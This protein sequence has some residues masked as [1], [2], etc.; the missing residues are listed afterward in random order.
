MSVETFRVLSNF[1]VHVRM[2]SL[3]YL[4]MKSSI[5][6]LLV[7]NKI[8]LKFAHKPI[9]IC[10]AKTINQ[11]IKANYVACAKLNLSQSYFF[12][13]NKKIII[14]IKYFWKELKIMP[15]T[16]L[17]SWTEEKC[18]NDCLK[19]NYNNCNYKIYL[20]NCKRNLRQKCSAYCYGRLKNA[21]R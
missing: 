1:S 18:N 3:L 12:K 6:V 21:A 2:S 15:A 11:L 14:I 13:K 4:S 20:I 9:S 17:Y 8:I 5:V 19:L 10:T 7:F 16:I